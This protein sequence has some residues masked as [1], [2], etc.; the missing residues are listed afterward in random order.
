MT[1]RPNNQS[2]DQTKSDQITPGQMP[3]SEKTAAQ[4]TQAMPSAHLKDEGRSKQSDDGQDAPSRADW[5]TLEEQLAAWGRQ[6]DQLRV[7][8]NMAGSETL[9][10]LEERYDEVTRQ[11]EALRKDA[12]EKAK[13]AQRLAD[14]QSETL[15][16]GVRDSVAQTSKSAKENYTEFTEKAAV[17]AETAAETIKETSEKLWVGAQEMGEGFRNAWEEMRKAFENASER[18]QEK[19]RSE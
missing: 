4:Q 9:R 3:D 11:A 17:H 5:D 19:D 12:E 7:R 10:N 1:N 15:V 6:L 8:A 14:Q 16:K 13:T 2:N 18:M